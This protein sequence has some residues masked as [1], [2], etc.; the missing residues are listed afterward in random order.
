[1]PVRRPRPEDLDAIA[2]EYAFA[3]PADRREVVAALVEGMLSAYDVLDGLEEPEPDLRYPRER[4]ERPADAENP[5]G[6]WYWRTRIEG[7]P[8]GPLAGR[9][10]AVKDNICVAG[11][12]MMNGTVTL[13]GYVPEQDATV[14]ERLLEAGVTVLG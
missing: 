5:L 1:M 10:L 9:T 2:R 4:G 6:A 11:V 14:V 7:D 12:P 8:D 3:I 13:E